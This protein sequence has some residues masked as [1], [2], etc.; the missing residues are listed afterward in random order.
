VERFKDHHS[1]PNLSVSGNFIF[2]T[3][4]LATDSAELSWRHEALRVTGEVVSG[5]YFWVVE[6]LMPESKGQVQKGTLAI[7]K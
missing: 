6:S 7:V 3:E 5:Y 2:E 1:N 4:H